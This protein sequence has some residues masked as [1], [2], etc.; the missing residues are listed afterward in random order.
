MEGWHTGVEWINSGALMK[1][2]NFAADMVGDVSRPGVAA[3]VDRLR[4][5]GDLSPEA[6]VDSCLDLMG[7]LEVREENRQQLIDH[8]NESGVLRWGDDNGSATDP[9]AE[10]VGEMLQ[11]VVSMREFQ[12]A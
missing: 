8:A 6:L 7:P 12:Y 4:S 10:R 5:L 2:V 3:M 1:R 11:L 9:A